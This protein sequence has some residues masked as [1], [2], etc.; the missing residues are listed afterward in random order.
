M[1]DPHSQQHAREEISTIPTLFAV[2]SPENDQEPS[3]DPKVTSS[4]RPDEDQL[5]LSLDEQFSK[6]KYHGHDTTISGIEKSFK[7]EE[8]IYVSIFFPS[9]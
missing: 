5:D 4:S 3:W 1:N 8:Y 6:L 9:M 2:K 7:D